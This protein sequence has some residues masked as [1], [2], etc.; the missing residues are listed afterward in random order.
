MQ[1][2]PIG[3]AAGTNTYAYVGGNPVSFFDPFG[4]A[5][6]SYSIS[7]HTLVCYPNDPNFVGPPLSLGPDGVFSGV[8]ECRNNPDCV[9]YRRDGPIPPGDYNMNPDTRPGRENHWRL[10]PNPP[11]P[12][13]KCRIW[14]ER[15]GFKLHPGS[16]SLGCIT[17]S[18]SNDEAMRQYN[19]IHDL[20]KNES[21]QNTL[22]VTP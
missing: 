8:G 17:T 1:S 7:S 15:C 12:G 6:C 18:K 4:L 5:R 11:I 14:W 22:K 10:E 9:D 19:R 3:L 2:D 13:W 21:G 20:L 16:F